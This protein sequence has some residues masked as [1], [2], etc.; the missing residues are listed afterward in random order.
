MPI[1][2]PLLP[3]PKLVVRGFVRHAAII[4]YHNLVLEKHPFGIK[5][6]LW[7][8]HG[9]AAGV[10]V[11]Y[12]IDF[13]GNEISNQ[14]PPTMSRGFWLLRPV[15]HEKF[16]LISC[17]ARNDI[18]LLG[19]YEHWC[20]SPKSDWGG[21]KDVRGLKDNDHMEGAIQPMRQHRLVQPFHSHLVR[22]ALWCT[23]S[24]P[25]C[26]RGGCPDCG[27]GRCASAY[28]RGGGRRL[29]AE[30]RAMRG[31]R[32]C[33]AGSAGCRRAAWGSDAAN[34]EERGERRGCARR[35]STA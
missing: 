21:T 31:Y 33:L 30:R 22:L 26:S 34:A 27:R 23:P 15:G 7:G 24:F 11:V 18:D 19:L 28:G 9:A 4:V 13:V 10:I 14:D 16:T 6:I 32:G 25:V 29:Y 12:L 17:L 3:L 35:C 1:T 20:L 2:D 5:E 8:V